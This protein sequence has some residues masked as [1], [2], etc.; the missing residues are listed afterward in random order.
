MSYAACFGISSPRPTSRSLNLDN[1][2]TA[3][4]A[5]DT[6]PGKATTYSLAEP[7]AD[8]FAD[9]LTPA[10]DGIAF[11]VIE[12][13][14]GRAARVKL[15]MPGRHNVSNALAALAAARASGA[16]LVE[17]AAALDRFT[18][19]QRRFDVVGTAKGITVIDDFG[20][21]P[22]KIAATLAT[23][24]AFP[25]RLI[26]L[27]QPQ[28]FGPLRMLKADF[29]DC[30][31]GGLNVDDILVMPEPIYFG[32]TT[33]RSVSSQDIVDGVAARGR[34][35]HG[36]ADRAACGDKMVALARVG[37]RLVVM[38]ARDDTLSQFAADLLA[39][40]AD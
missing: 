17:A 32:G 9:D 23:L 18:G 26:V 7:A 30:F 2:E 34:E 11:R 31:A 6:A 15:R 14:T 35:A 33:D 13:D 27:F 10:P 3:A 20:H 16:T 19:I 29:I 21:N 5:A 1:D 12:R 4:I 38:G 24:H 36:F 28:G 39:R 25:G 40:L 22:D 8:L 37:D